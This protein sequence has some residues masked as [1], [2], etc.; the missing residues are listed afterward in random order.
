VFGAHT[1]EAH[2]NISAHKIPP[3]TSE[4][5][6]II[7]RGG[8]QTAENKVIYKVAVKEKINFKSCLIY[9]EDN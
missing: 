6:K 1:L 3:V 8:P 4:L 7:E 9:T 2:Q 5:E